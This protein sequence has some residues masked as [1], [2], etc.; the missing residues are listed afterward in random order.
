MTGFG[1]RASAQSAPPGRTDFSAD[2]R[3]AI[4]N[5][6]ATYSYF[7]DNDKIDALLGLFSSNATFELR[8]PGAP[9]QVLSMPQLASVLEISRFAAFV[10]HGNQRRHLMAGIVFIDETANR[11]HVFV[12]ALITNANAGEIFT[13]VTSDQ[14]EGW[15]TK[16]DGAWKIQ[17]WIDAPDTPVPGGL[18]APAERY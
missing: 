9:A 4:Q 18:L 2:D 13:P 11:A 7:V 17:R 16:V 5:V 6:I 10:K 14:Y 15:F 3:L 12:E 1:L 8:Q